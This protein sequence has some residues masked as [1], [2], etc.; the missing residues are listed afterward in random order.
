VPL[1]IVEHD[2]A[3]AALLAREH[4]VGLDHLVHV[5][6]FRRFGFMCMILSENRFRSPIGV[7]DVLFGI[8][9]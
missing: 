6:P 7:E 4:F 2:V 1:G 9:H 3:D 5:V 8:M